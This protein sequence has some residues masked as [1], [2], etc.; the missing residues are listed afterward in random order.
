MRGP[1]KTQLLLAALTALMLVVGA[2]AVVL[3]TALYPPHFRGWGEVVADRRT[4]AGWVVNARDMRA[5]VEVQLYV[6]GQFA[7]A[8]LADRPRPDVVRAGR[9][10]EERCGYDF[11][12]PPL[13]PGEHEARVYALHAV[14]GRSPRTLLLTGT[15]LRFRVEEGGRVVPL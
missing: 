6:D 4:V 9:A 7:G 12:I 14:A 15:P 11:K 3:Y 2:V 5:R 1:H 8:G 13:A 10:D